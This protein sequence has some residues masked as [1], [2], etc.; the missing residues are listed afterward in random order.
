[1]IIFLYGP[2]T[3]RSR[4]KLKEIIDHYKKIHKTGLNLVFLEGRNLNFQNFQN[5]LKTTPMFEEKKLTILKDALSNSSFKKEL[6][7][8]KEKIINYNGIILFY[9]GK[10]IEK[11]DPFFLFLKE[12]SK[13]QEF[14]LLEGLKLRYWVKREFEKLK[15]KISEKALSKLIEFVGNDLWQMSNEI[16]KLVSYKKGEIIREEDVELL[17]KPKIEPDIFK[18]IDSIAKKENQKALFLLHQHFKKGDNPL[19]LLSMINFQFRNLLLI[20]ELIEKRIP[21]YQILN[22]TDLHPFVFKKS[23]Q[24]ARRFSFEQL[25]KI[26]QKIFEVDSKIKMGKINPHLGLDLLITEI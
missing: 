5:T 18:T 15:T 17:V 22:Q 8:N 25:K 6:E 9:E 12:N 3:Y 23:L 14:S 7:N 21:Y 11:E 10:E 2:D 1:M 13:S 16:K 20:R 24:Q 4:E 26:Y 19:Y